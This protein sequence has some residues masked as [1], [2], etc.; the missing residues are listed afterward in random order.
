MIMN[1][2]INHGGYNILAFVFLQL[3]FTTLPETEGLQLCSPKSALLPL[4]WKRL[5]I[6]DESE[7]RTWSYF[8]SLRLYRRIEI[9]LHSFLNIQDATNS[10]PDNLP[11]DFLRFPW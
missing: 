1:R 11:K 6:K 3:K 5:K 9:Y 10:A 2:H 4:S 8:Q 7:K